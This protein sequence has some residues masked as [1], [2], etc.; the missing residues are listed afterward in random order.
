MALSRVM[1]RVGDRTA[2]AG[3]SSY[4]MPYLACCL[5]DSTENGVWWESRIRDEMVRDW[6]CQ[7]ASSG[8]PQIVHYNCPAGRPHDVARR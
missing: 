1:Q 4:N 2:N 6:C 5:L 3:L 7:G 8:N